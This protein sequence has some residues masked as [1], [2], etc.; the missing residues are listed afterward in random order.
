M[1]AQLEER[2]VSS[3]DLLA[4]LNDEIIACRKCPRLASF[5][6]QVA[7][8][9]NPKFAEWDYWARPV[10]GFGDPL[11]SLLI[12]GLAP[13]SHGGNRTGRVFTGDRSGDF[14]IGEL[15][16]SGFA[17]Q[18]YSTSRED[19]LVLKNV[20]L[21]AAVKC[22]PPENKPTPEEFSNCRVYLY[23][24]LNLLKKVDAIL[25]LGQLAYASTASMLES[26]YGLDQPLPRFRHGLEVKIREDGP[27]LFASFHPS[28]RNTQTGKLTN[29]MF[30]SVLHRIKRT[31]VMF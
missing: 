7:L 9:K 18:P 6:R 26:M 16:K 8:A 23:R 11:A 3:G 30:R 17:S 4:K 12:V 22:A 5:R 15:Y 21:T 13:A 28:P 2:I 20:Y 31:I 25:C 19:G 24:E 14:L 1:V 10:S 29:E 27:T